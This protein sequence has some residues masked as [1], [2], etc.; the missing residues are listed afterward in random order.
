MTF[1]NYAKLNSLKEFSL[2][3]G[4]EY[5]LEFNTF[6]SDGV[7]PLDLAGATIKWVLCPYGQP[8][9]TILEANGTITDTSK[10]EVVLSSDSTRNFSGKYIQQPVVYSF[11][12]SEYRPAQGVILFLDS[13]AVS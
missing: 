3:A 5:T 11:L 2:I 9:Y 10:F 4:T 13:I 6:E 8:D 12:G 7:T 1:V